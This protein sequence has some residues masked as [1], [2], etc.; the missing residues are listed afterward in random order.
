MADADLIPALCGAGEARADNGW[1]IADGE[2]SLRAWKSLEGV[3]ASDPGVMALEGAELTG[4]A[5]SVDLRGTSGGEGSTAGTIVW[6]IFRRPVVC[7]GCVDMERGG[8]PE[9]SRVDG[10]PVI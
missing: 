1:G 9:G 2:K 3:L 10:C 5:G 6:C 8:G 4:G 7:A